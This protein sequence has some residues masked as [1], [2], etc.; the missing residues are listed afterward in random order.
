MIEKL[1]NEEALDLASKV[2]DWKYVGRRCRIG[3][4]VET[5][6]QGS[7][8]GLTLEIIQCPR[9]LILTFLKG[10][11][12]RVLTTEGIELDERHSYGC[13]GEYIKEELK[14]LYFHAKQQGEQRITDAQERYTNELKR[15]RTE[16]IARARALIE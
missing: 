8:D 5:V 3:F 13:W 1:T 14:T 12:L 10:Y 6:C 16:G 7:V 4:E 15:K 2:M 11:M 9:A